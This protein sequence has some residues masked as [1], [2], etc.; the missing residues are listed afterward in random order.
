MKR[1]ITLKAVLLAMLLFSGATARAQHSEKMLRYGDMNQWVVRKI[2]ES[3]VIGGK[4]KTLY[5]VG[6]NRT[7]EGNKPYTNAG[8]S[9]WGTSNVMAK[10]MGVVKTNCSVTRDKR[11]NG[12]CA[13]LTTHIESVRVLGMMNI[14]VLAAGSLFLGDMAEPI[15]GTKDG[16]K[17]LNWGIPFTARPKALRYDYK[18]YV[19]GEKNRIKQTGFSSKSTVPG[20]DYAVTVLFLQKRTEDAK[21]NITAKR[22]G[23]LVVKYGKSTAGWVNG[24]TY[25]ILYGDIRNNPKYDASLMGL[26]TTDY[27]RNS[28]GKSVLV[29]ET[30]WAAPTETPTHLSLQFASSHG[31]AFIGSPGNTLWIDNVRLVY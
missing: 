31:G 28:H 8:G 23:T 4:T 22:V 13:K 25:E 14:K 17:S 26:R 9:P 24:A 12:Y 27:A 29:K 3:A 21:G 5:E 2:H 16:P 19:T 11:D 7:I 10:V 1:K 6:P 18:V 30:G 15:T 20:Q